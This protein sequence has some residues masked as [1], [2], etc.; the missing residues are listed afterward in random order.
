MAV[1]SPDKSA[2]MAGSVRC[3]AADR[4]RLGQTGFAEQ[5]LCGLACLCLGCVQSR[6]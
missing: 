3:V 1:I 5:G 4:W 6:Q 2:D